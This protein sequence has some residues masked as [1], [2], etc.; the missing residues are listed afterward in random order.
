MAEKITAIRACRP[1]LERQPTM[2]SD[3][4]V[5]LLVLNTSL[6]EGELHHVIYSLHDVLLMAHRSGQAVKV[7]ELGTFTPTI[8][9]G[10]LNV[11]FRAEPELVNQLNHPGKI[12]ARIRNKAHMGRSAEALVALWN[13]E[14]PDDPVEG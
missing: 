14:H 8:R 7:D 6:T 5:E 1:E 12:S 11:S 9:K 2:G 4:L 3:K 13:Q 10:R